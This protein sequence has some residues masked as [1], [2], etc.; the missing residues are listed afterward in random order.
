[1]A[2]DAATPGHEY[3]PSGVKSGAVG[4]G[5]GGLA[6]AGGR[7]GSEEHKKAGF[8]D[9]LKGEMKVISGKLGHNEEK[10]EAGRKMMG[11]N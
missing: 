1:M 6:G 9:K 11:K 7:R 8:V 2:S 5:T 4:A 3:P 10:V